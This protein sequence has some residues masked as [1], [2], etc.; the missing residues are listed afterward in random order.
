[1]RASSPV[2]PERGPSEPSA[3]VGEHFQPEAVSVKLHFDTQVG[4]PDWRQTFKQVG[5]R[6][7][8]AASPLATL[9]HVSGNASSVRVAHDAY[10]PSDSGIHH[11][12]V[13][14]ESAAVT[15]DDAIE[16]EQTTEDS[17]AAKVARKTRRQS[18]VV[19]IPATAHLGVSFLSRSFTL[20]GTIGATVLG[21]GPLAMSDLLMQEGNGQVS[22]TYSTQW[23]SPTAYVSV[24]GA[25]LVATDASGA[26]VPADTVRFVVDTQ[27]AN[28]IQ[29]IPLHLKTFIGQSVERRTKDLIY[30]LQANLTKSVA[31]VPNGL[32]STPYMLLGSI[33]DGKTAFTMAT[34]A[35]ALEFSLMVELDMTESSASTLE[36]T[37]IKAQSPDLEEVA[38]VSTAMVSAISTLVAT[39]MSYR[40]DGAPIVGAT[41]AQF[42]ANENWAPGPPL[43]VGIEAD[44]CDRSAMMALAIAHQLKTS[45]LSQRATYPVIA[46][47][48][49]LLAHYD[50]SLVVLGA[51]SAEAS[52]KTGGQGVAGHAIVVVDPKVEVVRAV[53]RGAAHAKNT[54]GEEVATS[55]AEQLWTELMADDMVAGMH[56]DLKASAQRP[57]R[58]QSL[59]GH[60]LFS[61]AIEGTTPAY[62]RLY[63]VNRSHRDAGRAAAA[64]A[65]TSMRA[66]GAGL[67]RGLKD[68]SSLGASADV[69][70]FYRHFVERTS[71]HSHPVWKSSVLRQIGGGA[72]Q[73]FV[74]VPVGRGDAS[75]AGASP[76]E[77]RLGQYALVP[78]AF[79]SHAAAADFDFAAKPALENVMPTMDGPLAL[80]EDHTVIYAANR[81]ALEGLAKTS[82][83]R[84]ASGSTLL[85]VFA[86]NALVSN[87]MFI[88]NTLAKVTKHAHDVVIRDVDDYYTDHAGNS[89]GYLAAIAV[90]I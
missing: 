61:L 19:T 56:A 44:D 33:L 83:P 30:Q 89:V 63:E 31:N 36:H 62:A 45:T 43:L 17:L 42:Q 1:M 15:F 21:Q 73:Q 38:A 5:G 28:A 27:L 22:L 65:K 16:V 46:A 40:V 76:M 88:A 6:L 14:V 57:Y 39:Q 18:V 68:L 86:S 79:A 75:T 49:A 81:A 51:R 58:E 53:L 80:S 13:P 48:A 87:K 41:G 84:P 67:G 72:L 82:P 3:P 10:L 35:S 59:D 29:R 7:D 2:P 77:V 4:H 8:S 70:G 69:H 90:H 55:Y 25:R 74:Y 37:Y 71:P 60:P 85:Y 50:P 78:L 20:D 64:R 9:F 11:V 52:G 24:F 66:L 23:H 34:L 47:Y 26:D 32:G 12:S 54:L